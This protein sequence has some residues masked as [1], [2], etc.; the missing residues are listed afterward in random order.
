MST[1]QVFRAFALINNQDKGRL[2]VPLAQIL[3]DA[4]YRAEDVVIQS[5]CQG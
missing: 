5:V 1:R 3:L 4:V 2:Q